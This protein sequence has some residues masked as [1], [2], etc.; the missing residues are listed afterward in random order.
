MITHGKSPWLLAAA[1][2]YCV[3]MKTHVWT[4]GS[5]DFDD[6]S[7]SEA[8]AMLRAGKLVA[9]P[10]ETVYG[11]GANG[12]DSA[13][14]RRIY[15][16]KGRPSTNPVIL[17]VATLDQAKALSSDWPPVA[18]VLA[19]MFWPGPLTLIVPKA[20]H[21]PDIVTAG[22]PGVAIRIPSHPLALALLRSAGV[23]IAAPSA[24]ASGGVSPT[25]AAHV[26]KSLDGRI[27]GL[28]D[29][30]PTAKGLESTVLDLTSPP[31]ILRRPGPVSQRQL[32]SVMGPLLS[33]M[34]AHDGSLPMQSPGQM[35]SHYAPRAKL[36]CVPAGMAIA[37]AKHLHA[38]GESVLCLL[39][40]EADDS[41]VRSVRLP[42]DPEGYAAALYAALHDA[43]ELDIHHIV[44]EMPPQAEEW[45]AVRDRL[46]RAGAPR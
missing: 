17:H 43:D 16:A 32:E 23:P 45:A 40:E 18:D 19:A 26:L 6:A 27:D 29:G 24:N 2:L 38:K 5:T 25:T 44:V 46:L 4:T 21:V 42:Q 36:H 3:A 1:P 20:A 35:V 15:E 9:F 30:G 31:A 8:G 34:S 11:L 22:L 14:V 33:D 39:R 10:T 28:L 13:A 41:A 37:G 12:L 7:L